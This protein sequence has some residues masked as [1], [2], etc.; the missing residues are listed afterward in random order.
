M[1]GP[2][3]MAD[4]ESEPRR[5]GHR[6]RPVSDRLWEKVERSDDPDG[7]WRW[8]GALAGQYGV[9]RA[10]G[11]QQ[12][13]HR[14]SYELELGPIPDGLDLN[15]TCGHR[16]CIRPGHLTPATRRETLLRGNTVAA[17]NVGVTHCPRGHEYNAANTHITRVGRRRC[18]ECDRTKSRERWRQR[19]TVGH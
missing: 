18:R 17:R 8:T 9:I 13:A 16:W 4:A 12:A 1:T 10:N 7:C 2:S 19:R 15:W 5:R 6:P 11:R 3:Q 14:V